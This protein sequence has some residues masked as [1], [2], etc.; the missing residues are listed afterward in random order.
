MGFGKVKNEFEDDDIL[1][2]GGQGSSFEDA[3][4]VCGAKNTV[5]G[6]V[7]F[8]TRCIYLWCFHLIGDHI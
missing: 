6:N 5:Q 4:I 8:F 3:V 7:G 2:D 1:F